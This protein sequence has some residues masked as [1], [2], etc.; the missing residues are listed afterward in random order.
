MAERETLRDGAIRLR[1]GDCTFVVTRLAPRT[2][3]LG[4]QGTD[5]GQL[6]GA[7]LGE[8][9]AEIERFGP[10][11]RLFADARAARGVAGV[12]QEEWQRWFAGHR[13]GLAGVDVLVPHAVVQLTIATVRHLARVSDFMRVSGDVAAFESAIR[14]VAPE[15]AG[16]P[17][18]SRFTEAPAEVRRGTG[19]D[20]S[21][22]LEAGRCRF[23][24]RRPR[25]R[26]V[27]VTIS[28][29][30][31]GVLGAAPLDELTPDLGRRPGRLLLFVDARDTRGV[32]TH[33]RDLWSTWFQA[34][35][36]ELEVVHVL[37]AT[38][39]VQLN[40]GLGR[41]LSRTGD[42]MRLHTDA[43]GFER[44]LAEAGG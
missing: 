27:A 36:D 5:D 25:A 16:L 32:A 23:E 19:A 20:G 1:A 10:P 11:L 42:L 22:H 39:L 33:V 31:D 8:M 2:L 37:S 12:V 30:D 3:L 4:V 44:A 29:H 41:Q 40:L 15:F 7:V 21:V 38:P 43:G 34:H 14:S 9:A 6:G 26:V 13:R 35:R 17:P 24:Y 28:G 18:A